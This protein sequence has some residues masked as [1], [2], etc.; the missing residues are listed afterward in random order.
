M[1]IID[2]EIGT[3]NDDFVRRRYTAIATNENGG[4]TYLR[5]YKDKIVTFTGMQ[6]D[7][8]IPCHEMLKRQLYA[9]EKVRIAGQK[10][11]YPSLSSAMLTLFR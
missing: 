2:I 5:L 10:S 4:Y 1:K 7:K 11:F 9:C 3:V 8:E 6:E